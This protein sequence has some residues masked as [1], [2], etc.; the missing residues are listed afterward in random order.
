MPRVLAEAWARGDT[1][2]ELTAVRSDA[3]ALG[4]LGDHWECTGRLVPAA[5]PS[6]E[7]AGCDECA[8]AATASLL[9]RRAGLEQPVPPELG[10]S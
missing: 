9:S 5:E 10:R 6:W 7:A 8:G 3:R 4:V 2:Q 1:Q